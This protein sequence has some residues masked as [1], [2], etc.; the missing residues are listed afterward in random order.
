MSYRCSCRPPAA[1]KI[2]PHHRLNAILILS[3]PSGKPFVYRRLTRILDSFTAG[4]YFSLWLSTNGTVSGW[5]WDVN[6]VISYSAGLTN[7]IAIAAGSVQIG[8]AH[9]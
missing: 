7:A 4:N 5:G 9:V 2:A 3:Q 1:L 6:G 8:R